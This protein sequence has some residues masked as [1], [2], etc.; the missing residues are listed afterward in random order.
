MI[1]LVISDNAPLTPNTVPLTVTADSTGRWTTGPQDLSAL[2]DTPSATI[3]ATETDPSGNSGTP[4]S[5][6]FEI[7]TT[8]PILTIDPLVTGDDIINFAEAPSTVITGDAE[9]NAVFDVIIDDGTHSIRETVTADAAGDWSA[10]FNFESL[11][12]GPVV[13]TAIETDAAGNQNIVT[14]TVTKNA[15]QLVVTI[16]NNLEGDDI[17]NSSEESAATISGTGDPGTTVDVTITDS[18]SITAPGTATVSGTGVWTVDIDV[19]TLAD[20]ILNVVAVESDSAGNSASDST[21]VL[22]DTTA[23]TSTT[24]NS[25]ITPDNTVN[26][27]EYTAVEFSG[28]GEPYSSILLDVTDGTTTNSFTVPVQPNGEWST[29][30]SLSPQTQRLCL[31]WL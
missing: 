1:D 5:H 28:L 11:D 26:G 14:H 3:T 16:D 29:T 30:V 7:D 15:P 20:G 4:V 9:P 8:P 19:S 12:D 21:S 2:I 27:A 18:N 10:T 13:I 24:I 25:P 17:I 22:L 23:S 6:T 31:I